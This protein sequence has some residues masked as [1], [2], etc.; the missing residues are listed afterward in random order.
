MHMYMVWYVELCLWEMELLLMKRQHNFNL[1]QKIVGSFLT[2]CWNRN[3]KTCTCTNIN[4]HSLLWYMYVLSFSSLKLHWHCSP[5]H[6]INTCME[7]TQFNLILAKHAYLICFINDGSSRKKSIN[8]FSI[9]PPSCIMKWC[10]LTLS[11]NN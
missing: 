4:P 7:Y 2:L 9:S 1:H 6:G 11:S 5:S 10:L 8:H 3:I